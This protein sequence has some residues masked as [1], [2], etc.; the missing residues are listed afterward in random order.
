MAAPPINGFEK[1]QTELRM[2]D[3]TLNSVHHERGS[4]SLLMNHYRGADI[5]E[6]PEILCIG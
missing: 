4:Y 2:P 5:G 3:G 1:A 6:I